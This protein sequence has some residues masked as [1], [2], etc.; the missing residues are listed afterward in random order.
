MKPFETVAIV[1]V[2]LIGGSI[3]LALRRR[4][5]AD[6]VV[7]IGRRQSTLR[8]A[9]RREAITSSTTDVARGVA[10][11]ELVVI[12]TPVESIVHLANQTAENCPSNTIITDAGSTKAE[13]VRQL[14]GR[15]P[16]AVPFLGS[17]P[18]AGSEQTGP[19]NADENLFQNN[20]VITTPTRKT[21]SLVKRR[22]TDFWS[23]LGGRVVSMS[24]AEHDR[25]VA[26]VSHLPHVVAAALALATKDKDL[27][28]VA[29]GWLDTTRIAAGDVDLWLEI[30]ATN[31]GRVL[32]SLKRFETLCAD[33]IEALESDDRRK[34]RRLLD[35]AKQKRDAANSGE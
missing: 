33:W 21:D 10:D 29:S 22:V 20:I 5:L 32:K 31:R 7:G 14:D 3:G 24:P 11:A 28:Y 17:H 30:L 16:R 26:E 35:R 25:C 9:R 18:M 23:A 6:R 2:G 4:G 1:G 13:I 27:R 8:T 15:L 19:A 12:C 34:L